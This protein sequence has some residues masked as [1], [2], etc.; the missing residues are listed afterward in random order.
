V[1]DAAAVAQPIAEPRRSGRPAA[2]YI[3]VAA[4][5]AAS[6]LPVLVGVLTHPAF[7]WVAAAAL[8]G[9][10]ALA[11][12]H[13]PPRVLVASLIA[14][15]AYVPSGLVTD[16]T[17]YLPVAA[18][19]GAIAVRVALDWRQTRRFVRPPAEP[20]ALAIALYVGW[21]AIATVASIDRRVS[22]GY[23]VGMVAVCG[24]AFWVVPRISGAR[25]DREF[26]LAVV[27][28]AGVVVAAT[29]Y[30]LSVIGGVTVFGRKVGDHQLVDLTV[31]GQPTGIHVGRSAGVFLAPLEPAVI[32]V[33]AILA[34]L[35]WT[36]M[37]RGRW[38]WA[39]RAGI[40][41]IVP[42]AIL[43][44]DRSAWL[45]AIIATGVFAALP[46]ARRAAA[47]ISA[48]L[49]L[50]FAICFVGV[51]ANEV[52]ANAVST[53]G[54]A[55]GCTATAPGNDEAALRGGTGLSGRDHLWKASAEA[56]KKRPLLGYGPGNNV[57]AIG[58]YLTGTSS[59]YR[60]LTS[61]STWLRT[62]V[63]EGVPGLLLLIG[64]LLTSTWVFLRGPKEPR[65]PG[66]R[67]TGI[68]DPT[69]ATLAVSMLGM[70][71][72]MSFE[73]FFLGGVNFSNLYLALATALMLP[74]MTLGQLRR[75]GRLRLL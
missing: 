6:W 36:A 2:E 64:V 72:V 71:G 48:V 46:S 55:A 50:V 44:L 11:T 24:L 65:A 70:L 33:M 45:G 12:A 5:V 23:W 28:A 16:S 66:E 51:L 17:H 38:M 30:A 47:V 67:R 42:A 58:P 19:A 73:S 4:L 20:V 49:C 75:S 22:V 54:C 13:R 35:G 39:G 10:A 62:A 43:T 27:G 15:S 9:A 56:I 21:A 3:G 14:S 26:L 40:A 57:P 8:A 63:E 29:V 41:F 18:V 53:N 7:G 68:P 74:A 32:M 60:G 1:V 34:L 37:R 69:K 59:I 52:G 25:H 31:A 61:H